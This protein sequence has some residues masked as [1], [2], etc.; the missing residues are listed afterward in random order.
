MGSNGIDRLSLDSIRQILVDLE[1]TIIFS[2]IERAKFPLNSPAY[3]STNNNPSLPGFY[4]SLME[5]LVKG[6]EA[7]HAQE[8]PSAA[9]SV[10]VNKNIWDS[11]VNQFLPLLAS[12]GDDGNYALSV[13]ADLVC[14]QASNTNQVPNSHLLSSFWSR[15]GIELSVVLGQFC[16][17]SR[18]IHYGKFVGETKFRGA[19]EAYSAAI[20]AK[21]RETIT[22]LLTDEK[23]EA[24]VKQR[25]KKKSM[26]FGQQVTL[27][28]TNNSSNFKVDPSLVS[29]L[30]D[31]LVIPL[32]KDVEVEYLLRRLDN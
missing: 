13:A 18:R 32:T 6:T 8:L 31:E 4:G 24:M 2:L 25:V 29:R 5:F 23:V 27:N 16:A 22:N 28:D 17:I 1:D 12:K 15:I 21:D 30:Y 14:L 7:V 19:T 9:A 11:Y 3:A 10:S 20:R 26:I